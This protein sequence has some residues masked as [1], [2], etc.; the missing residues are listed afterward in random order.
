[1]NKENITYYNGSNSK[2]EKSFDCIKFKR[3][4]QENVLKAS[5]AKNSKEF[6]DFVNKVGKK[7]S[8][9]RTNKKQ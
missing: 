3:Q 6:V 8:L 9:Y 5:K 1:M 4:L 2:D 7:S